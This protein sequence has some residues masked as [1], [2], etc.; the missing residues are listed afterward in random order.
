MRLLLLALVLGIAVALVA[1][2]QAQTHEKEPEKLRWR[3]C[4]TVDC[5]RC[6][7]RECTNT[8]NYGLD[9][10]KDRGDLRSCPSGFHHWGYKHYPQ[11]WPAADVYLR[12]CEKE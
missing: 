7:E 11:I 10:D 3:L 2:G 4:G 1:A 8:T 5:K 6:A 12:I 9:R